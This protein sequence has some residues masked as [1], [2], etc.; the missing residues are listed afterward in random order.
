[1]GH[2]E[3]GQ[4]QPTLTALQLVAVVPT[5]VHAVTHPEEGLAELVLARELVGGVAF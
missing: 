4:P 5:V 1:M 2:R 3:A